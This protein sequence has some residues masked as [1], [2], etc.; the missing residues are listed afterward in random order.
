MNFTADAFNFGAYTC[1]LKTVSSGSN[2]YLA[3][4][5]VLDDLVDITVPEST[6]HY[7]ATSAA[8]NSK[9]YGRATCDPSKLSDCND[10]L[11]YARN[12]LEDVCEYS[13]G[14]H[15]V[16]GESVCSMQFDAA[17]ISQCAA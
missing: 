4:R 11:S 17:P 12:F 5:S 13:I 9:A 14:G 6:G 7:C 1:V 15:V 16:V 10:C 2:R 3:G 8:G